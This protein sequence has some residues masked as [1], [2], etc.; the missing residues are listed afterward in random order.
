MIH[1]AAAAPLPPSTEYPRGTRGGAATRPHGISTWQP[2]RCHELANLSFARR[3]ARQWTRR[4]R[5]RRRRPRPPW[6]RRRRRRGR[7]LGRRPEGVRS[8]SCL[9]VCFFSQRAGACE[10]GAVRGVLGDAEA[11]HEGD[12]YE[13]AACVCE[14]EMLDRGRGGAVARF[15][16]LSTS[17]S[18]FVSIHYPRCRRGSSPPNLLVACPRGR[19]ETGLSKASPR[20]IHVLAAVAPRPSPRNIHVPNSPRPRLL[21]F[22][23]IAGRNFQLAAVPRHTSRRSPRVAPRVGPRRPSL[24]KDEQHVYGTD[25]SSIDRQ[26]LDLAAAAPPRRAANDAGFFRSASRPCPRGSP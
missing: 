15:H 10:A 6:R 9:Q 8:L 26:K 14:A 17:L 18:R 2:R 3:L 25:P 11:R 16:L 22:A 24:S 23:R 20:N 5:R 4:R 13:A 12:G 19:F 7:W 1:L 21:A